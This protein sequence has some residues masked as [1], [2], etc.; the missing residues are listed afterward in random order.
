MGKIHISREVGAGLVGILLV[1]LVTTVVQLTD[2]S[3]AIGLLAILGA[4]AVGAL[5]LALVV[6]SDQ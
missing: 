5:L 6:T 1:G 2:A 3:E 4:T